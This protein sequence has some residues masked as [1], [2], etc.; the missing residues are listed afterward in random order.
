[1]VDASDLSPRDQ[2]ILFAQAYAY[3]AFASFEHEIFAS[4]KPQDL[5]GIRSL[6]LT[7]ILE[8][9][10]WPACN[11]DESPEEFIESI[12]DR[13]STALSAR[14]ADRH[15]IRGFRDAIQQSVDSGL[16]LIE[17][18]GMWF[19]NTLSL[20]GDYIDKY[21]Q[22]PEIA[23]PKFDLSV[24]INDGL[25]YSPAGKTAMSDA[26]SDGR[27]IT[28]FLDPANFEMGAFFAIPALISHEF[29]CHCLSNLGE[30][31]EGCEPGAAFEEGWMHYVQS[32]IFGREMPAIL[33]RALCA[34]QF[35]FYAN[36]YTARL[37]TSSASREHGFLAAA[38][39]R[40]LLRTIAQDADSAIIQMSLDLNGSVHES[41][42]KNRF[43][44]RIADRLQ[45]GA[46]ACRPELAR[47]QDL[48]GTR[49][50]LA[51]QV[52]SCQHEKGWNIDILLKTLN[53]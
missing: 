9:H 28:V 15:W 40:Y 24:E 8:L 29:W 37:S 49:S 5:D 51:E 17:L 53:L 35:E 52:R 11:S 2:K 14:I 32:I 44:D 23:L 12:P 19:S 45:S 42:Y 38:Q 48:I 26:A 1:M 43:V 50:Q 6:M 31:I 4:V 27:K 20:G 41:Q 10:R 22:D 3:V 18:I 46:R 34:G 33:G 13:L 39:F 16:G 7:D 21:A 30:P 25:A 36:A 47:D